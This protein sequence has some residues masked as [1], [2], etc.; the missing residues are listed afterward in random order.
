MCCE[1]QRNSS[2]LE[3]R[4]PGWVEAAGKGGDT[5]WDAQDRAV[6]V[7]GEDGMTH[8][9]AGK[10]QHEFS[11]SW[12]RNHVQSNPHHC[13]L[14]IHSTALGVWIFCEFLPHYLSCPY[15]NCPSI[16]CY[17]FSALDCLVEISVLSD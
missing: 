6:P 16:M 11:P 15:A 7:L 12:L 8:S 4:R 1:G 5:A 13:V 9:D 3:S 2:S 17:C 14:D 10:A